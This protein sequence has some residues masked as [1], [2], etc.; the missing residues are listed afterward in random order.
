MDHSIFK[1][2]LRQAYRKKVKSLF[3]NHTIWV[4]FGNDTGQESNH[5][6]ES[7]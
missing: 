6:E 1:L 7:S 2:T 4:I 3:M 5:E